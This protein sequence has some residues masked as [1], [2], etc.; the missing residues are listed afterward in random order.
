M[1]AGVPNPGLKPIEELVEP[2]EPTT[3]INLMKHN[4][5]LQAQLDGVTQNVQKQQREICNLHTRLRE[6]GIPRLGFQTNPGVRPEGETPGEQTGDYPINPNPFNQWTMPPS[7]VID[8]DTP[9][10]PMGENTTP[11]EGNE[12]T[13]GERGV[14][15]EGNIA[16]QSNPG[17]NPE[18]TTEGKNA[19]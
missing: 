9:D 12:V 3:A 5:M 8:L 2:L 7:Q 19:E 13:N 15:I 14:G 10:Q 17:N 4:I 6:A 18:G 11:P 1:V 16:G